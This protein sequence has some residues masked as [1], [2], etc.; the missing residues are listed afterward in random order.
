LVSGALAIRA[1]VEP[2]PAPPFDRVYDPL[3]DELARG[4]PLAGE[5]F[6]TRWSDVDGLKAL[7]EAK[8]GGIPR[9]LIESLAEYHQRLGAPLASLASLARLGRGEAVCT[10]A[11][12][13]PAPL[14]GPL[15]ALHKTAC[16]V[17]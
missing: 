2:R 13:Q 9:D 6:A 14:G 17:G 7:A 3:V 11:G 1:R 8:R 15:Y 10:V 16:A 4:G 12:Q 5:R